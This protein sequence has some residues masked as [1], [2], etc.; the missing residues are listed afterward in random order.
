MTTPN[1]AHAPGFSP[2]SRVWVY[3]TERTL[4]DVE[5]ALAQSEL[6]RFVAQWTAHNAALHAAA[7]VWGHNFLILMVDETQA[8]ASGCS[9]DKSVHFLEDLGRRLGVDCFARTR[10]AWKA[11]NVLHLL[12]QAD[13]AKEV[14][15][16]IVTPDTLVVNSLAQTKADLAERWLVPFGQSWHRRLV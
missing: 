12:S 3:V 11:D 2:Q 14:Q 4:T 7:E 16:G 13:F 10:F 8:G 9:I 15:A 5:A 6:S 1:L